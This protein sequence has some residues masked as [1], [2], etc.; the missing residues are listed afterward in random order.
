MKRR[1]VYNPIRPAARSVRLMVM[2][3]VAPALVLSPLTAD[4]ILIHYDGH[5]V[6]AHTVSF[7][8][9]EETVE[10]PEHR[11]G[12]HEHG[13]RVIDPREHG[14][15][16][17]L[18]LVDLPDAAVRA[19][20]PGAGLIVTMSS[21]FA[22]LCA[23]NATIPTATGNAIRRSPVSTGPPL[24]TASTVVTILLSN[25]ALLL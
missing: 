19:R 8:G 22:P 25:H 21:A 23:V 13:N 20:A 15:R 2:L 16:G 24:P 1:P 7:I 4:A 10:T 6:H 11:H 3:G 17:L 5:D 14:D 12:S 9:I 18:I